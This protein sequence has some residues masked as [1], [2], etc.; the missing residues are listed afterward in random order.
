MNEGMNEWSVACL[1][2][3]IAVLHRTLPGISLLLVLSLTDQWK[4]VDMIIRRAGFSR[5]MVQ[6]LQKV[7]VD[8]L[9]L[10]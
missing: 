6:Q 3:H 9:P 2:N 5:Q 1:L 10:L 8:V 4:T 7:D